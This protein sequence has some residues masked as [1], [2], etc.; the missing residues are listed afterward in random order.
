MISN[1]TYIERLE[2]LISDLHG[3]LELTV[4]DVEEPSAASKINRT[5]D[6]LWDEFCATKAA[7][8]TE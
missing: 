1:E 8:Y 5:A 3:Q 4:Y 6:T 2:Q 7:Y